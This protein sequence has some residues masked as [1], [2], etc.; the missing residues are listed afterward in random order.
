M[1]KGLRTTLI[2]AVLTFSGW[3]W[4]HSWAAYRDVQPSDELTRERLTEV[5]L[6]D[7][8]EISEPDLL[9]SAWVTG[10]FDMSK[11]AV[12]KSE[13][14]L[15]C[16]IAILTVLALTPERKEDNDRR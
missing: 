15:L 1:R 9:Y 11:H 14:V 4:F 7:P 5:R 13:L 6:T 2:L 3:W 8:T 16:C 10:V 12:F